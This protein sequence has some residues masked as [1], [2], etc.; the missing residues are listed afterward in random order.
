ME[1]R[2]NERLKEVF[3]VSGNIIGSLGFTTQEN[4]DSMLNGDDGISEVN[5]RSVYPEPFLAGKIDKNRLN[6]FRE[7]KHLTD[8]SEFESLIILSV[9]DSLKETTIDLSDDDCLL[10]L[11]TTKGDIDFLS[12][13][14]PPEKET[15]LWHTA[16]RAADYFGMKNMP[17]VVSDACISGVAAVEIAAR[18]LRNDNYRTIVVAGAD[19]ITAFTVS[20][21]QA[22]KSI[23]PNPCKPYDAERDGLSIGEGAASIIL[24]NDK[25]L[26]IDRHEIR[27]LGGAISNDANHISGPSRTGDGLHDAI[28]NA[29]KHAGILK[30]DIDFMNL[31]GTATFYNDEMESK[32]I[33]LSGLSDVP[34]FGLKGFWG[35]TLGA[36][37]IMEILV[38]IESLKRN[39][40][41]ATKGFSQLG[42]PE[43]LNI[44]R[45][46]KTGNY[47]IFL[48]TASGFG[49]VNAAIIISDREISR[50][51][52]DAKQPV[53]YR[54]SNKCT[55]HNKQVTV[56]NKVVFENPEAETGEVFLKAAFKNLNTAYPKF[57]KMDNLS[58]L[59][60]TAVQY[61][62]QSNSVSDFSDKRNT[63]LVFVN[64]ESSLDTD[65]RHQQTINNPEQY[66]P[67]PAI[68]VYTLPNIVMGEI[69]I[70]E[71]FQGETVFFVSKRYD[72]DFINS[73]LNILFNDTETDA[74]IVG[75]INYLSD[76]YAADVFLVEKTK[77]VVE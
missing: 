56:N 52:S 67:S 59:G 69:C 51:E 8:Y 47:H 64:S 25:T 53:S 58:K 36:S 33:R 74:V 7:E 48:K 38:C 40:L 4:V 70:K 31:H 60:F 43:P 19:S 37:G 3:V 2:T 24:T 29:I 76:I 12:G 50:K 73:Y 54:I 55:I 11:S 57:Y 71:K 49:G 42:T 66:F 77:R 20:G 61:L 27:I 1:D 22:F 68:F 6:Q 45:E 63:A 16:Q 35:H 44:I 23:S 46:N 32:A 28:E 72:S 13:K 62:L 21:F 26:L 15:Y 39:R 9:L 17:L 5:D 65:I 10:I 18:L 34:M 14:Y 30:H 41:I 75:K